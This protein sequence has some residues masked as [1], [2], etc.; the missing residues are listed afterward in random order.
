MVKT[1]NTRVYG[2]RGRMRHGCVAGRN[3]LGRGGLWHGNED[4]PEA[5]KDEPMTRASSP[6]RMPSEVTALLIERDRLRARL[7]DV[8]AA[9]K[10]QGEEL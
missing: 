3:H 8:E 9:L 5:R 7:D 1:D 6:V 2:G 4:V 10:A